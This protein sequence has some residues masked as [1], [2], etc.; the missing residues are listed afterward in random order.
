M[1]VYRVQATSFDARV[2]GCGQIVVSILSLRTIYLIAP[3]TRTAVTWIFFVLFAA[4][5]IN[6]IFRVDVTEPRLPSNLSR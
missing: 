3:A 1:Y 6:N 4:Y 5:M 2:C